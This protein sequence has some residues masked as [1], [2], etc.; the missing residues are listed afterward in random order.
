MHWLYLFDVEVCSK[1]LIPF[2]GEV[3]VNIDIEWR[4]GIYFPQRDIRR[5]MSHVCLYIYYLRVPT[6]TSIFSFRTCVMGV[7]VHKS[8]CKERYM[9]LATFVHA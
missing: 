2:L 3:N 7:G 5:Y 1:N 8:Q 9:T 4:H 6:G